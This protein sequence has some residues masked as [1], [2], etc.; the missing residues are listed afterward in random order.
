[1]APHHHG[2]RFGL[3]L[4]IVLALLVP[5]SGWCAAKP[6]VV[7]LGAVRREPYSPQGDPAGAQKDETGLK[8][9]PLIVD[10]KVRE[11]TTGDPHEVTERSFAVRRAVRL[12]DSLP[13][14]HTTRWVWQRG[15]WLLIDRESGKV[16]ALHLPDFDPAVSDAI[17]FRDYAAYCGVNA[18]GRQLFAV[19]AQ[20]AA[21]RPLLARKLGAWDPADHP[22]PACAPSVWQRD[23]LKVSFQPTGSAPVSFD[24]VGTS[25]VL[26]EDGDI[27]SE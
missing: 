1:M 24:L 6:H 13:T 7:A 16:A 22:T 23:P 20:I 4:I 5:A 14:D 12:N 26:V 27:D 8:V 25:A 3:S 9:R 2:K 10:G 17:W 21:H 18:G 15:P 19:V 11:W